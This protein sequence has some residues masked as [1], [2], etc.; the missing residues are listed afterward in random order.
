MIK[1]LLKTKFW[2]S[3]PSSNFDFFFDKNTFI[4]LGKNNSFF[5][6][7]LKYIK[8]QRTFL[9][10]KNYY[11]RKYIKMVRFTKCRT[12]RGYLTEYFI[13]FKVLDL[14]GFSSIHSRLW[15]LHNKKMSSSVQKDCVKSSC[16]STRPYSEYEPDLGRG[17]LFYKS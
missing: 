7:T 1:R 5:S 9:S 6:K 17:P 10:K 16:P 15:F 8:R 4:T 13:I 14:F 12:I 2:K 3:N 11:S